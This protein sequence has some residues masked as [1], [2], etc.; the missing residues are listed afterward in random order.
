[1]SAA[2]RA[3]A[4][5]LLMASSLPALAQ[6]R[7]FRCDVGGRTVYADAPCKD[8]TDVTVHDPRSAAQRKAAQENVQR[9]DQLAEKMAR[10]RHAR[11]KAAATRPAHIAYPAAQAAA[12][13]NTATP[14]K[15]AKKGVSKP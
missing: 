2:W 14:S 5:A 9:E 8:A 11:E 12:S 1:M 3:A 13:A 10:E 4:L 15:G 7:V 6:K